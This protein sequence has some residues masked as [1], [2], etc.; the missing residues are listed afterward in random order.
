[1]K[2]PPQEKIKELQMRVEELENAKIVLNTVI[3]IADEQ[4]GTQIRKKF[5]AQ[6]LNASKMH[7]TGKKRI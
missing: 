3:D 5:L 6:Q 2:Q 7:K 4:F 1:M